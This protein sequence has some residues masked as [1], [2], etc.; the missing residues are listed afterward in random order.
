VPAQREI[1]GPLSETPAG[2]GG[3]VVHQYYDHNTQ[4]QKRQKRSQEEMLWRFVSHIPSRHFKMVRYYGFLPN[5]KHG[6]LQ[7]KVYE[8]LGMTPRE[9]P[10]KL[11]F[12]VLMKAFLGTDP[13]LWKGDL[14]SLFPNQTDG[15]I[16]E[17]YAGIADIS[18]AAD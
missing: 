9:K 1:P 4:Q 17:L 2:G 5:C 10:L 18:G 6:L 3:S 15:S 16:Q 11:G 8:A 14:P 12:A 13:L 7:P